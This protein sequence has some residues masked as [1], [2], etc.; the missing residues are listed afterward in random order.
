MHYLW[1][2]TN[3]RVYFSM[4]KRGIREI[5]WKNEMNYLVDCPV[6]NLLIVDILFD[7]KLLSLLTN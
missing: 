4:T 2:V 7:P 1:I 3:E 6:S 5:F